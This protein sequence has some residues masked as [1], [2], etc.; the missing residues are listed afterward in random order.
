[1]CQ[2]NQFVI[3]WAKFF[4]FFIQL[5]SFSRPEIRFWLVFRWFIN[6]L[7]VFH[8]WPI[9]C[10]Y[11]TAN[12]N[13]L[14]I[15]NQPNFALRTPSSSISFS[16]KSWREIVSLSM[17]WQNPKFD[18]KWPLP[19]D[20]DL[21]PFDSDFLFRLAD[22]LRREFIIFLNPIFKNGLFWTV[23]FLKSTSSRG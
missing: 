16:I 1:M 18:P 17:F 21:D 10:L 8:D 9:G 5:V 12:Q 22:L 15:K 13:G 14:K 6:F 11:W 19:T 2:F 3:F 7:L 23:Y 20:F 4:H